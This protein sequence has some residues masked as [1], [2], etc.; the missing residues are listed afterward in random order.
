M[1][2]EFSHQAIL[3]LVW[4]T[5]VTRAPFMIQDR[6]RYPLLSVL[7]IFAG[8]SVIIQ[9]WFGSAVNHATG[10]AQF[11]NFIQGIWS[12]IDI[13]AT[14]AFVTQLA[15]GMATLRRAVLPWAC[16]ALLTA[17]GMLLFFEITPGP[18]RFRP[19]GQLDTFAVYSL[20][21][22]A[23]VIAAASAASRIV[24]RHLSAVH[25]AVLSIALSMIMVADALMVPFMLIRTASRITS[26]APW[27]SE[28]A[29]IASTGR[30]FLLPLGCII[31]AIW[32]LFRSIVYWQRRIRIYPLWCLLRR[33]TPDIILERPVSRYR[34]LFTVTQ[35]WVRLHRRVIDIRD[36]I[37]YLYET[38]ASVEMIR[39]ADDFAAEIVDSRHRRML[40]TACWLEAT[41]LAAMAGAPKRRE[42]VD[43]KI[44]SELLADMSTATAE[45]RGLLGL[46]TALHAPAV[47]EF[48]ES[49]QRQYG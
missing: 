33:A 38:W 32:P 9:P 34:D 46:Y 47:R 41:R 6:R 24:W 42:E 18:E 29:L 5:L 43:M 3:F 12:L 44:I 40:R 13:S 4:A 15:D 25:N 36:S 39:E 2:S 48:A 30:F 21:Q 26:I 19:V 20:I 28:V 16:W 17:A 8:S 10:I 22:A 14:L 7:V 23:Y 37:F 11:N 35:P 45:I 31:V 49:M 27:L 1:F